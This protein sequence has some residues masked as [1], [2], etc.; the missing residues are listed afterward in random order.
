MPPL[1]VSAK[2]CCSASTAQESRTI[3]FLDEARGWLS[4]VE[5]NVKKQSVI[6]RFQLEFLFS[7]RFEVVSKTSF[8]EREKSKFGVAA[9]A[10]TGVKLVEIGSAVGGVRGK[11]VDPANH[12]VY[13]SCQDS[14]RVYQMQRQVKIQVQ[15]LLEQGGLDCHGFVNSTVNVKKV[16]GAGEVSKHPAE[17]TKGVNPLLESG[18]LACRANPNA[19]VIVAIPIIDSEAGLEVGRH[20]E[21]MPLVQFL[22]LH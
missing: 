10:E 9:E 17:R 3:R 22:I 18:P 21:L 15:Q 16:D 4:R 13:K 8:K 12:A 14:G 11:A 5:R 1:S 2:K 20:S 6:G 19:D 7:R